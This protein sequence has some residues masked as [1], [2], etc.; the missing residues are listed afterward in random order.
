VGALVNVTEKGFPFL[1]NMKSESLLKDINK[2][3]GTMKEDGTLGVIIG[4]SILYE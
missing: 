1:K 2:A 3:L 4:K